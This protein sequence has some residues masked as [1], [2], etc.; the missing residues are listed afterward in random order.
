M[1][2]SHRMA[3]TN[4]VGEHPDLPPPSLNVGVIGWIR[5]NL[6]SSWSDAAMTIVALLF[7]AWIIPP[8]LNWLFFDAVWEGSSAKD[9]LSSPDGACWAYVSSRFGLFMY[10]FFPAELR[11]RVDLA[12][13]LLVV[14]MAMIMF[15]RMP[16]RN[17][18]GMFL[19]LGYPVIAFFLL[20]GG[21]S[22]RADHEILLELYVAALARPPS[23]R[24]REAAT[25]LVQA[26]SGRRQAF[27]DVLWALLNSKEFLFRR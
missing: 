6:I 18:L 23:D 20:Y 25:A 10:G 27:E 14:P 13:L 21:I 12:A 9:C 8:L 7:L 16:Y 24:E 26:A 22:G 2:D 4:A 3:S 1:S 11:W 15:E 17:F 5:R 19:L